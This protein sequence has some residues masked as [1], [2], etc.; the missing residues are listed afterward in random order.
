MSQSTEF[1]GQSAF[2]VSIDGLDPPRQKRIA[3]ANRPSLNFDANSN[4][5]RFTV[6]PPGSVVGT[7]PNAVLATISCRVVGNDIIFEGHMIAGKGYKPPEP[8]SDVAPYYFGIE[9]AAIC[10]AFC[11]SMVHEGALLEPRLSKYTGQGNEP[12]LFAVTSVA[13]ILRQS[14][15][16]FHEDFKPSGGTQFNPVKAGFKV[17]SDSGS[18]TPVEH[19]GSRGKNSELHPLK[20]RNWAEKR[21]PILGASG[22]S[23]PTTYGNV[24]FQNPE[25]SENP[26]GSRIL[27]QRGTAPN[28][29]ADPQLSNYFGTA[30]VLSMM[31]EE[32]SRLQ[33]R[34]RRG[35][36][37]AESS[38]Q[39]YEHTETVSPNADLDR[40]P[41]GRRTAP[42][43]QDLQ[44]E[45]IR[46]HRAASLQGSPRAAVEL[47]QN[48][49]YGGPL[50]YTVA[51]DDYH[52][53][54]TQ[55]TAPA[56]PAIPPQER[57]SPITLL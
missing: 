36:A 57:Q 31:N 9:T 53:E 34:K 2:Q 4:L 26:H 55:M 17:R 45:P 30:L 13:S 20:Q 47:Y 27:I 8:K 50:A 46:Q 40:Q 29:T 39:A 5:L 22:Y 43:S 48:D 18:S 7:L 54:P 56:S 51:E 1:P 21:L 23:R 37:V 12:T 14:H 52:A 32:P 42:D 25:T 49:D 41:R 16:L 19:L 6:Y 3:S 35:I 11:N 33:T 38:S 28:H 44:D 10:P 24:W 15:L